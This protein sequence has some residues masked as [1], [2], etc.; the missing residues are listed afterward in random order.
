MSF[1]FDPLRRVPRFGFCAMTLPFFL[2]LENFLVI[3]PTRQW[4][5]TI[6]ARAFASFRPTTRGTTHFGTRAKDAVTER[7]AV[8][9]T[10]QVPVP[11]HPPDQPVKVEPEAAAAERVTVAPWLNWLEQ[12]APQAIPA[13]ELV[14]AHEPVPALV[15]VS[16]SKSGAGG[17]GGGG[18][19]GAQPTTD[20][21][22][23][24]SPEPPLAVVKPAMFV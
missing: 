21:D 13:G 16:V 15:T 18:G 8:I 7:S 20:T 17:G 6:R 22:A 10:V 2:R 24:D 12:T 1:T 5:L 3:F 23:E 14:T 9:D 11:E 4:A 19:G